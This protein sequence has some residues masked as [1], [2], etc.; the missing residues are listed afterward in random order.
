MWSGNDCNP[1]VNDAIAASPTREYSRCELGE[2]IGSQNCF[3][4]H[5]WQCVE[6]VRR[7]YSL[8]T[9]DVT[10][11]LD[12][13]NWYTPLASD[14]IYTNPKTQV[15]TS[16][17]TEFTFVPNDGSSLP[18][19]GD[20][21]VFT[22]GSGHVAIISGVASS[23][24]TL[25]GVTLTE[26]NNSYFG[27]YQLAAKGGILNDRSGHHTVGWLYPTSSGVTAPS[28]PVPTISNLNPMVVTIASVGQTVAITGTG[29]LPST[30]LSYNGL[31][32]AVVYV[33]A[34]QL[35]M[36]LTSADLF[37]TGIYPVVAINPAPGGGP[38]LPQYLEV[39]TTPPPTEPTPTMGILTTKPA[40]PIVGTFEIDISQGANFD[41]SAVQLYLTGPSCPVSQPC[42]IRHS[43]L[44][45]AA[46]TTTSLATLANIN[47]SGTFLVYVQNGP[48]GPSS[49]SA[50]MTVGPAPPTN[51]PVPTI[52]ILNPS[53]V[54]VASAGQSIT[55][56][57]TGF[58][59]STTLS[60]NGLPHAVTYVSASQ[61]TM[62]L[63]NADVMATGNYPIIAT[64][65]S[66]G[67]GPSEPAQQIRTGV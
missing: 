41:T 51:N 21:M 25:T 53:Q 60:Y 23:G 37:S 5:T 58:M 13:S 7:F 29:F 2:A 55:I 10:K 6:Y 54:T 36:T 42:V 48:N 27:T 50:S 66:P 46:T 14:F 15:T 61:L 20:I 32:H 49:A 62:T 22:G 40:Q 18:A 24:A 64:N 19:E 3:Y 39:G 12:T 43:T 33:S 31:P 63:A 11:R 16:T 45:P 4:G 28:N 8:R 44:M 52:T 65:P 34:T 26:Q 1:E 17:L 38:S 9:D 56:T 67:G 47:N 59:S 30:T 35:S 57:G